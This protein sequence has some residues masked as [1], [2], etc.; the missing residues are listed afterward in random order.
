VIG[1]W[2]DHDYGANN[3][4][5]TLKTKHSQREIYLD[6]IGEPQDTQRRLERDRGIYQDY[7]VYTDDGIK[8]HIILLDVRFHYNED[9]IGDRLG[10]RQIEWLET[11]FQ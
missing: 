5:H 3:A 9:A 7:V 10:K 8:V 2:D 4:G 6:F 1:I 11:I